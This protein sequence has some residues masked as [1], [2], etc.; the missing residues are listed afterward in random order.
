MKP[1]AVL[2]ASACLLAAPARR[3]LRVPPVEAPA[4]AVLRSRFLDGLDRPA[5]WRL[6]GEGRLTFPADPVRRKL[7]VEVE[8]QGR[9]ALPV[10]TAVRAIAGEDWRAFNRL[11]LWLRADVTG[12]PVLTMIVT[13]NHKTKDEIS[14]V[15]LRESGHNVTLSNGVWTHVLWEIPHL[16]REHVT[17]IE[18][19]PWVNKR[20]PAATERAA[21]E[22]G[23][24]EL[25]HVEPGHYGGWDVA[26]GH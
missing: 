11:S 13:V 22:I 25:Q 7:R 24:I 18:F 2:L 5:N 12:F 15:H 6:A 17:S 9:K 20:L 16:A 4:K 19:R 3:P 21:Y 26:P 14:E 1:F 23:P 10:A 8:L